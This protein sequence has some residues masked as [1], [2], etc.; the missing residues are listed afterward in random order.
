M[1][2]ERKT[3]PNALWAYLLQKDLPASNDS[4][5]TPMIPPLAPIDRTNTSMRMLIHDM[6]ATLESSLREWTLCSLTSRTQR[7]KWRTV[8]GYQRANVNVCSTR[9]RIA[10]PEKRKRDGPIFSSLLLAKKVQTELKA[11]IGAPSQA[12]TLELVQKSQSSAESSIQALDKRIDAIQTL[13]QTQNH[14]MQ[15]IQDQQHSILTA[16]LP[17]L[18]LVQTFPLYVDQVKTSIA[19]KVSSSMSSLSRDIG[20][21]KSTLSSLSAPSVSIPDIPQPAL[22]VPF[23]RSENHHSRKRSNSWLN[24][25]DTL[26]GRFQSYRSHSFA[27][28][29]SPRIDQHKKPRLGSVLPTG[30]PQLVRKSSHTVNSPEI[31]ALDLRKSLNADRL[32]SPVR[33]SVTTNNNYPA[34]PM[35]RQTTRTPL[36]DILPPAPVNHATV[37][38]RKP[39]AEPSSSSGSGAIFF[40]NAHIMHA[41]SQAGRHPLPTARVHEAIPQASTV[42]PND[43]NI[44]SAAPKPDDFV[45]PTS[46]HND[47][48]KTMESAPAGPPIATPPMSKAIKLEEVLR[49]PL[50]CCISIP[51]SPLSSLSPSPLPAP[52]PVPVQPVLKTQVQHVT[53]GMTRRQVTFA[54]SS[55]VFIPS[56]LSDPGMLPLPTLD[57]RSATMS[58]R[59][60]RAQMSMLGRTNFQCKAF[61]SS[62][63]FL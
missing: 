23:S 48:K 33:D 25:D 29:R 57:S 41:S 34:V 11:C 31:H 6:Q 30:S 32:T 51:P 60:R 3:A 27:P 5:A 44:S 22:A 28:S 63:F 10:T 14:A 40:A 49:S 37:Q 2:T 17:L 1:N 12:S 8:T 50:R 24:Q 54:T 26:P 36:A 55:H 45:P 18:P 58:L 15:A 61:Y 53:G 39:T 52:A 43:S 4:S 16:V 19:D 62:G 20:G 42:T 35:L 13:I 46:N 7:L 47:R 59:D 56:N 21:M 9:S 38:L